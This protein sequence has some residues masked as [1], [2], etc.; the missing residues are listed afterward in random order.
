MSDL[1]DREKETPSPNPPSL[2]ASV[3][4]DEHHDN[5]NGQ[6]RDHDEST[7]HQTIFH[8]HFIFWGEEGL[9]GGNKEVL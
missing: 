3:L 4:D 7:A 2:D 6:L 8:V 9:I 5:H 1:F